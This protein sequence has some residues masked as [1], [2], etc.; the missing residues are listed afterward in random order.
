[1]K[2]NKQKPTNT[3]ELTSA[4]KIILI[5]LGILYLF[6]FTICILYPKTPFRLSLIIMFFI[7]LGILFIDRKYIIETFKN[8]LKIKLIPLIFVI[9]IGSTFGILSGSLLGGALSK[10]IIFHPLTIIFVIIHIIRAVQNEYFFRILPKSLWY[11]KHWKP[12]YIIIQAFSPTTLLTIWLLFT[13][14]PN[15]VVLSIRIVVLITFALI[16]TYLELKSKNSE[17]NT[18][19]NIIMKIIESMFNSLAIIM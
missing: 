14:N 5:S 19:C 10:T 13:K 3:I 8:M 17:L 12:L 15:I 4:K 6:A 2:I 11:T 16:L 7:S 1:M 9:M 18:L